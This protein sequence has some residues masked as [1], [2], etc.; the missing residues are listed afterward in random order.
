MKYYILVRSDIT[1]IYYLSNEQD[2]LVSYIRHLAVEMKTA[3]VKH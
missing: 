2:N 1:L 3:I